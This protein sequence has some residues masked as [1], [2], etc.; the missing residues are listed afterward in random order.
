MAMVAEL[1]APVWAQA[2][3]VAQPNVVPK[4]KQQAVAPEPKV[5]AAIVATAEV[6]TPSPMAVARL[7]SE[8]TRLELAADST[9][10]QFDVYL[11]EAL[12]V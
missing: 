7:I 4:L 2:A 5:S 10:A 11:P 6:E 12:T 9:T 8:A 1:R 3:V